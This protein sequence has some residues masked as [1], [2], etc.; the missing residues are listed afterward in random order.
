MS[1]S[2]A[3]FHGRHNR[4]FFDVDEWRQEDQFIS[5]LRRLKWV[6]QWNPTFGWV[7]L[8]A[9]LHEGP[10]VQG[11]AYD[12]IVAIGVEDGYSKVQLSTGPDL[13]CHDD[14][15]PHVFAEYDIMEPKLP[16]ILVAHFLNTL[17]GVRG[18]LRQKI[19]PQS[20][21]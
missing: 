20:P 2:R 18:D 1:K 21:I 16:L 3:D 5:S 11:R 8:S 13:P 14:D 12:P 9:Y 4:V 15:V 17:H 6:R 7:S 10:Y 19:W